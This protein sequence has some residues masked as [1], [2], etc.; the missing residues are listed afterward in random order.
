[1]FL[2]A[3]D[4]ILLVFIAD[5][6]LDSYSVVTRLISKIFESN[7]ICLLL[8]SGEILDLLGVSWPLLDSELEPKLLCDLDKSYVMANFAIVAGSFSLIL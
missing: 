1:M 6:L 4:D 7:L 2:P 5:N 8:L 3:R